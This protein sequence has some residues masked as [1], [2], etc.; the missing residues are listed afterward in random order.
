[1][2]PSFTS[3]V[4]SSP[5]DVAG[6][7]TEM[8]MRTSFHATVPGAQ[9]PSAASARARCARFGVLQLLARR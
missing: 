3:S 5:K 6:I 8:A 1:M 2:S 7:T 4:A 9:R